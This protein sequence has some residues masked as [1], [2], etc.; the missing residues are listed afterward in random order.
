MK[1]G[2]LDLRTYLQNKNITYYDILPKHIYFDEK[3]RS[4]CKD[5]KCREYAKNYMCPPYVG[6][7]KENEKILKSFKNG[8][9]ILVN[10]KINYQKNRDKYIKLC[11]KLHNIMLDTEKEAYNLGYKS[12][13]TYIGGS[14]KLCTPCKINLKEK[15]KYPNKAKTS[16]EAIGIDVIKS[17]K[18]I[19]LDIKFI[20]NKITLIGLI[21][22]K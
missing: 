4:Y 16:M 5:N 20:D 9:I 10:E 21:M 12:F 14:C 18:N 22:F 15:C 3:I 17:C 13:K 7:V 6:E 1:N 2:L 11:N 19:G 8:F